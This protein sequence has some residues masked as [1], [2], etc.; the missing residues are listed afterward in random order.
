MPSIIQPPF[1][2]FLSL[3]SLFVFHTASYEPVVMPS[4]FSGSQTFRAGLGGPLYDTCTNNEEKQIFQSEYFW[5]CLFS[6]IL[7]CRC[8]FWV[9]GS[10][11]KMVTAHPQTWMSREFPRAS[12]NGTSANQSKPTPQLPFQIDDT[13]GK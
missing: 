5:L 12:R 1:P 8:S 9:I 7:H 6:D 11:R 13:T 2:T 10:H 3:P 4:T